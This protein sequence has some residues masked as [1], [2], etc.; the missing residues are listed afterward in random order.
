M[1]RA[2]NTG[3][4]LIIISQ[5]QGWDPT[6]IE[7]ADFPNNAYPEN[8]V[9]KGDTAYLHGP[10]PSSPEANCPDPSMQGPDTRSPGPGGTKRGH[11]DPYGGGKSEAGA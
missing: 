9:T 7:G 3:R 2:N 4:S 10:L 6:K 8:R 11:G 1:G 5:A